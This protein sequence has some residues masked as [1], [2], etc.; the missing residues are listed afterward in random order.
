MNKYAPSLEFIKT[1]EDPMKAN[2]PNIVPLDFSLTTLLSIVKDCMN[3]YTCKELTIMRPI[4]SAI[5]IE[6]I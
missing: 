5:L 6:E 2:A 3:V 1:P 4:I